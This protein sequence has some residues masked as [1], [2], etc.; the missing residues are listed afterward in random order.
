MD[1]GL[2]VVFCIIEVVHINVSSALLC[3]IV[4]DGI[5]C[6]HEEQAVVENHPERFAYGFPFRAFCAVVECGNVFAGIEVAVN[7]QFY[8]LSFKGHLFH[9][10]LINHCNG[11]FTVAKMH[12]CG[13]L[14]EREVFSVL[15][16]GKDTRVAVEGSQSAAVAVFHVADVY[17]Y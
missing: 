9:Y 2:M 7:A 8:F 4:E 14:C 13:R 3:G 16:D 11:L 10:F 17:T 5:S 15:P 12:L 1:V 6:A